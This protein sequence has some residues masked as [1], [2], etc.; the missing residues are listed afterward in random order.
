MEEILGRELEDEGAMPS[1]TG[2]TELHLLPI[3]KSAA[4]TL[5]EGAR[6]LG[7]DL[8]VLGLRPHSSWDRLWA[9]STAE[10]LIR[11]APSAVVCV[12][13]AGKDAAKVPEL[14]S[15][16]VCTDFSDLSARAIGQAVALLRPVGG[17][18]HLVHVV[19]PSATRTEPLTLQEVEGLCLQLRRL[20]PETNLGVV[21]HVLEGKKIAPLIT[22]AAERLGV[23]IICLASHGRTGLG[24]AVMGS[25]AQEVLTLAHVPVLV[26]PARATI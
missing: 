13:A 1:G 7:P 18:L 5:L 9:G 19:E 6:A 14:R 17:V 4:E 21:P 11:S 8:I 24:R 20:V 10:R 15:A 12:P 25:V 22:Q 26:V 16:L 3:W 2:R 23:S